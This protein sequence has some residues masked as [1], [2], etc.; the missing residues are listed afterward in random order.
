MRWIHFQKTDSTQMR[1]KEIVEN[2]D[3]PLPI[4]ITADIQTDGIGTHNKKWTSINGNLMLTFCFFNPIDQNISIKVGNL[5][6]KAIKNKTG[7]KTQFKKPND[8]L[9]DNKKCAGV[10]TSFLERKDETVACIGIGLNCHKAPKIDQKT[11]YVLCNKNEITIEIVNL[12][13]SYFKINL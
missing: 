11:S 12:I 4:I 8:I 3:T 9:Y 2:T 1:A 5:I 6:R 7:M 10:I 13:M